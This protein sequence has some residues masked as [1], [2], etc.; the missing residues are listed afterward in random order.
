[1]HHGLAGDHTHVLNGRADVS[2]WTN[3][4]TE[5]LGATVRTAHTW[6][7]DRAVKAL[8]W[9][10]GLQMT[11]V[12]GVH[13]QSMDLGKEKKHLEGDQHPPS[14]L[15]PDPGQGPEKLVISLGVWV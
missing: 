15:T 9:G 7:L 11:V 10:R 4:E 1:M 5:I 3:P 12:L 2:D 13:V 8:C 6:S 14:R